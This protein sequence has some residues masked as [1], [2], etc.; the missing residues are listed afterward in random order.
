MLGPVLTSRFVMTFLDCIEYDFDSQME[1]DHEMLHFDLAAL[2]ALANLTHLGPKAEDASQE[3]MSLACVDAILES[4]ILSSLFQ[5]SQW[6]FN[7]YVLFSSTCDKY[8]S[9]SVS[10]LFS[11]PHFFPPFFYLSSYTYIYIY[12][13]IFSFSVL[14]SRG[15]AFVFVFQWSSVER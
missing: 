1:F 6:L 9:V 8:L 14:A 12:F 4:N 5:H 10:V 13:C 3:R 15:V 7:Q 2:T 11:V